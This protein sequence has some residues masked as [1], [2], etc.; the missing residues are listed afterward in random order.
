MILASDFKIGNAA[1]TVND[2]ESHGSAASNWPV[3][4]VPDGRRMSGIGGMMNGRVEPK[5][6]ERNLLHCH[7]D[8]QKPPQMKYHGIETRPPKRKTPSN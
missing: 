4:P 3:L 1:V 7:P 8:Q 2:N 6:S 5:F